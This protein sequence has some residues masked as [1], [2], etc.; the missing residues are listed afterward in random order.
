M[1]GTVLRTLLIVI[2][3]VAIAAFF[4]G[5]RWS[6]RGG[7]TEPGAVGTR[8]NPVDVDSA[9]GTGAEI[10]E[11]VAEGV[12]EGR[13]LAADAALTAKIKSKMALDDTIEAAAIDVDTTGGVVTLTGTVASDAQRQRA[14]HLARETDG[15]T[16]VV[17][18]LSVR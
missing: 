12:N 9:R 2:V 14:M 7:A 10:G 17:D 6:D 1:V 3:V 18:R 4:I 11:R 8:G 5:Y 13:A 15:V 16:S